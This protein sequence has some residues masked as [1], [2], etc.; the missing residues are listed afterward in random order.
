MSD[1]ASSL[2]LYQPSEEDMSQ[3][4]LRC[5]DLA[6]FMDIYALINDLSS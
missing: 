3:A 2:V 4:L 5:C 6:S 1:L